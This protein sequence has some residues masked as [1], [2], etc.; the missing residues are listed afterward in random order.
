MTGTRADTKNT[1]TTLKTTLR[2]QLRRTTPGQIPKPFKTNI[3]QTWLKPTK[4]MTDTGQTPKNTKLKNIL[5]TKTLTDAQA[6]PTNCE[7][8]FRKQWRTLGQTPRTLRKH[9]TK[10]EGLPGWPQTTYVIK[11]TIWRTRGQMPKHEQNT[12]QNTKQITTDTPAD[13]KRTQK[14]LKQI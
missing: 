12:F 10:Y 13:L 14:T 8:A 3:E 6:D 11:T 2:K 4:P 5:K 9:L 1:D 7:K